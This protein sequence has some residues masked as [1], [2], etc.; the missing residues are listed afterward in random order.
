MKNST[1]YHD[2]V[3]KDGKLIGR[4]NDM[5]KYSDNIPWHQDK[6]A[7]KVFSDI[8]I[9]ILK[10]HNYESIC[11]IGCGL[12]YFANRL[13]KEL[14]YGLGRPK[15]TGVEISHEAVQKAKIQFP[16]ICFIT[17]DLIIR[18]LKNKQKYFDCVVIKATLWY[19]CHKLEHFMRNALSMI[20]EGGF[21]YVSQSFPEEKDWV[22]KEIIDS[23]ERLYE[24]LS[25]YAVPIHYCVEW[26]LNYSG[27]PYVHFLGKV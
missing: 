12:G 4:F 3:F 7:Y 16:E 5:Y 25:Q 9:S 2:Y 19:V 24:I 11:E 1:N 15:V 10:Q 27:R 23:P 22:G 13:H 8:D 18:P 6:T 14:N 17:E 26:E 20:K 21:L